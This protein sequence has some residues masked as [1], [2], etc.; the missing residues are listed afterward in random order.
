MQNSKTPFL[1]HWL[2]LK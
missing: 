2:W 1:A